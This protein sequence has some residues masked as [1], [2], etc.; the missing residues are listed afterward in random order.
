MAHI[1]PLSFSVAS[2]LSAYR[3]VIAST[4]TAQ[5]V[6]YPPSS[7]DLPVGITLD[8]VKDTTS[9]IEVAGPGQIARLYFNDSCAS[10]KLVALD[11]SGRGIPFV[12]VTAGAAFVGTLVS[13]SVN[14]TGTIADVLIAPGFKAIP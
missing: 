6:I 11:S 13:T 9:S 12:N 10:G 3:G 4:T 5:V 8:T 2:T 14:Q 1:P 7:L